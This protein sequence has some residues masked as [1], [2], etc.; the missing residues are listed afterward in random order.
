MKIQQA[1]KHSRRLEHVKDYLRNNYF[2]AG[3]GEPLTTLFDFYI[4]IQYND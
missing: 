2:N 3:E 1:V 4:N